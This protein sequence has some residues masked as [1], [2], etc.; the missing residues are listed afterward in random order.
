MRK[1]K[2]TTQE[3]HFDDCGSDAAPLVAVV[4]SRETSVRILL[5]GSGQRAQS[6]IAT[7][8]GGAKFGTTPC[9]PADLSLQ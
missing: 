8:A 2:P 3:Q 1:K 9:A 6:L 5:S 7:G 4:V